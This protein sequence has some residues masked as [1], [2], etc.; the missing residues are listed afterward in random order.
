M[1]N[2]FNPSPRRGRKRQADVCEGYRHLGLV[3]TS[4]RATKEGPVSR[5]QNI[6]IT[7]GMVSLNI[8]S[9]TVFAI[10]PIVTITKA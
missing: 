3:Y 8:L 10:S 5:K 4:S 2:A 9:F 1:A 6:Q 7:Y